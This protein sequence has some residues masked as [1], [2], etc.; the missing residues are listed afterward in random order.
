[1][2]LLVD[3]AHHAAERVRDSLSGALN[4]RELAHLRA[5]HGKRAGRKTPY[6]R[7]LDCADP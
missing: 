5:Q 1:M 2:T 7:A 6:Y 3:E 4:S